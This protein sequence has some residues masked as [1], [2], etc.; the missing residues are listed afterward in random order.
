MKLRFAA[1]LSLWAGVALAAPLDSSPDFAKIFAVDLSSPLPSFAE[2]QQ[3]YVKNN[4]YDRKYDFR[5][6]SA[7]GLM[8]SLPKP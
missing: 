8:M 7:T 1:I 6:I 5:G 3:R 4:I 2:L